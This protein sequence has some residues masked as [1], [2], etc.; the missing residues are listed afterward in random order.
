MIKQQTSGDYFRAFNIL[1]LALLVGQIVFAIIIFAVTNIT[2]GKAMPQQEAQVFIYVVAAL[3]FICIAA[4]W[5]IFKKKIEA[6][7]QEPELPAQLNAYR[8]LYIMRFALAEGPTL[9]AII[10]VFVTHNPLIW[11]FVV[12]GIMVGIS[13][14]PSKERLIKEL[15]LG[16]DDTDKLN[17]PDAVVTEI[18]VKG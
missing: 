9:F 5:S 12:I 11:L 10:A 6:I 1:F 16:S 18:E 14:K 17:D 3:M 8:A 4:N 7:K 2:T 15:Q 13:L